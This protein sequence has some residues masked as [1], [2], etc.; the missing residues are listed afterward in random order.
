MENCID[1]EDCD[2]TRFAP[3]SHDAESRKVPEPATLIL[4]GP[5]LLGICLMKIRKGK[6]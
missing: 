2:N 1:G 3:F 6:G 5:G 4:L